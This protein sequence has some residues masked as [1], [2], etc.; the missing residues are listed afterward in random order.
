MNTPPISI[1]M[2]LGA[3]ALGAAGQFLYKTGAERATAGFWS[4]LANARLLA[5]V[6]CYVGVMALF[7]AAFKKGGSI[8]VLYPIYS[9]TFIFAAMIGHATGAA[10]IRLVHVAGMG[11]LAAG[12]VCMGR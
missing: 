8:S 10:P 7:V 4:Y 12:M 5:G 11:L 9:S 2:F 1:V 6:A 3:S